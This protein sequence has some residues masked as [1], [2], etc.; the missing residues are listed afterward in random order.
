MNTPNVHDGYCSQLVRRGLPV[1]YAERAAAEIAD[2]HRDLVAELH[3]EGRDEAAAAAEA[4]RRLGDQRTLVKKTVR[5]YQRR[6]WCGRWPLLTFFIAPLPLLLFAWTATALLVMCILWPF[7]K[8]GLVQTDQHDG[9][10]STAEWLGDRFMVAM[11]LFAIPAVL[12]LLFHRIARRA[13]L[14][15]QWVTLATCILA[16]STG[17]IRSGFADPA[18]KHTMLDGTPL[19]ADAH[20]LTFW[21]PIYATKT[22]T[23]TMLWGSL[24]HWFAGDFAQTGQLLL[25]LAVAMAVIFRARTTALHAEKLALSDC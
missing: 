8:L 12:V 5:E 9:I 4:S 19:P 1:D 14:G 23:S 11:F 3:A 17:M 16:F 20:V 10:I 2:H 6:Y 24:W 18:H 21:L 7:T 22:T 15:W 13:A 25:P